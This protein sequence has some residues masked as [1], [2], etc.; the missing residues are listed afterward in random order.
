M[1]ALVSIVVSDWL[2][3]VLYMKPRVDKDINHVN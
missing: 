1:L 3:F 2:Q